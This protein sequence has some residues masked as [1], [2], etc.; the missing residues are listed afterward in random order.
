MAHLCRE[1]TSTDT[2]VYDGKRAFTQRVPERAASMFETGPAATREAHARSADVER[3]VG[4][5]AMENEIL[6]KAG[7]LATS[8]W[9]G[10]ER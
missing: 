7:V 4:W 6:P 2:L 10:S 5:L 1:R 8:R 3:M 9:N